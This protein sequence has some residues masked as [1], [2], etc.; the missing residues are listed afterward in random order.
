MP[1]INCE[2]NL[3]LNWCDK[4]VLSNDTKAT[5]FAITNTKFYVPVVTLW[6]QDNAKLHE[7]L[8]SSFKRKINWKKYQPKVSPERR[9]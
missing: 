4:C 8:R 1:L 7:Q 5:I 3:I 2:I 6:T 9:N